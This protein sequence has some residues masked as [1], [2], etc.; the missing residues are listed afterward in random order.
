MNL[1]E[2]KNAEMV[3]RKVKE[4]YVLI[5]TEMFGICRKN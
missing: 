1:R 5:S 2:R 4:M 3:Q